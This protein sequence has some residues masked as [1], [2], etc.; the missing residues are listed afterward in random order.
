MKNKKGYISIE[1]VIAYSV[2]LIFTLL[3]MS[4]FV[5]AYSSISVSDQTYSLRIL[6]TK[7]G[8]LTSDDID[9]FVTQIENMGYMQNK[10]ETIQIT[11]ED[12]YGNSYLNIDDTS[13]LSSSEDNH[14]ILKVNV[15]ANNEFLNSILIGF[16]I[17]NLTGHNYSFSYLVVSEKY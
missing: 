15:P 4:F 10:T 11:L 12:K 2:L 7:H 16:D 5:Y 3:I 8:G 1:A 14:L 9:L 6:A 17:N 13:Y